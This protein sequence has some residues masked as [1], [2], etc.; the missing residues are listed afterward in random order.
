ME[1]AIQGC[2]GSVNHDQ[3]ENV[4]LPTQNLNTNSGH[5]GSQKKRLSMQCHSSEKE[6]LSRRDVVSPMTPNGAGDYVIIQSKS[7]INSTVPTVG[8]AS[9]DYPSTGVIGTMRSER[10]LHSGQYHRLQVVTSKN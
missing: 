7:D 9:L 3:Y 8:Y 2:R 1:K 6:M 10:R 4:E 5:S